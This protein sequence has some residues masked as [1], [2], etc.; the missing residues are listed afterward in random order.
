MPDD[1]IPEGPPAGRSAPGGGLSTKIG[2]LPLWGWGI[3][4]GGVFVFFMW[5]RGQSST[6]S[7]STDVTGSASSLPSNAGV[8][9]T[10]PATA[11][12]LL[13]A[14]QELATRLGALNQSPG[15]TGVPRPGVHPQPPPGTK[16]P[17]PIPHPPAP[18]NWPNWQKWFPAG[19]PGPRFIGPPVT[20]PH[21]GAPMVLNTTHTHGGMDTARVSG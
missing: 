12:A 10:D 18:D 17:F 8:T 20:L 14:M 7:T 6:V 21:G 4:A 16:P 9:S 2:P 19:L 15:N 1:A 13:Q 5:R 3:V 11:A